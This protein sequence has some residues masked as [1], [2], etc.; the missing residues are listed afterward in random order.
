MK[1]FQQVKLQ[2]NDSGRNEYLY[3][4]VTDEKGRILRYELLGEGPFER[5]HPY[6]NEYK[7][8][9]AEVKENLAR[10]VARSVV[11]SWNLDT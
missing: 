11:S 9:E 1:E 2:I 5:Q 6:Y 7:V 8:C 10:Y 3:R 4:R